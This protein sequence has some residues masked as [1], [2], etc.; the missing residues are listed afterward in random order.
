MNDCPI[1]QEHK[2]AIKV[3][4]DHLKSRKEMAEYWWKL[5]NDVA[6]HQTGLPSNA[7]KAKL[8]RPNHL[9]LASNQ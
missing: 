8:Q 9:K 1:C 5:A 6:K 4:K 3:L 7:G 2:K